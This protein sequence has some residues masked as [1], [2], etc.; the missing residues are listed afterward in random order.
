MTDPGPVPPTA[1]PSPVLADMT[2]LR[3]GGPAG[4]V[5]HASTDDDLIEAVTDG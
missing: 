3:V 1:D 2:T 4:R 5:I